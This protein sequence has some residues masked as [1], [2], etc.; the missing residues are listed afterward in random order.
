MDVLPKER[1]CF[2][3]L[4]LAFSPLQPHFIGLES[5]NGCQ[6]AELGLMAGRTTTPVALI[7]PLAITTN[8][9]PLIETHFRTA[10]AMS[11]LQPN[12]ASSI[13]HPEPPRQKSPLRDPTPVTNNRLNDSIL[14]NSNSA[15]GAQAGIRPAPPGGQP[16]ALLL[17]QQLGQ[18][19]DGMR[20]PAYYPLNLYPPDRE[21]KR[22]DMGS[23]GEVDV[24]SPSKDHAQSL[25]SGE[26]EHRRKLRKREKCWR[27]MM[28]CQFVMVLL[29][30]V[31]IV[32]A[33]AVIAYVALTVQ[34]ALGKADYAIHHNPV[35]NM[36]DRMK[37]FK[38]NV[39]AFGHSVVDRM[40]GRHLDVTVAPSLD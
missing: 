2:D 28:I 34:E 27:G 21:E 7:S 1:Y 35:T 17:Q 4:R 9:S 19:K 39:G 23:P 38:S 25:M 11:D 8:D 40:K 3:C 30:F 37:T 6:M 24:L 33:T 13:Q 10:K 14:H 29:I 31:F 12:L 18:Y 5:G 15:Q 32:V 16:T 36:V 20:K 26:S 22:H